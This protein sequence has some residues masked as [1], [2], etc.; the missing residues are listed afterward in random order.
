MDKT[1]PKPRKKIS[2]KQT[3]VHCAQCGAAHPP[4]AKFCAECGTPI[5]K[6]LKD[7]PQWRPLTVLFCD[8][9]GSTSLAE[10][11]DP[12]EF[13][14][15]LLA[16]Q[17]CCHRVIKQFGGAIA[18]FL[19]DGVLAY[20]GYPRAYEHDAQR[21]VEASLCLLESVAALAPPG[22]AL[23]VRIGLHTGMVIIGSERAAGYL[24]A[25]AMG[26]TPHMAARLQA[27]AQP[28]TVLLSPT[29]ARQV[30]DGFAL[31]KL[32]ARR[33]KGFSRE[34]LVYQ[35]QG[36]C[37]SSQAKAATAPF[38]LAPLI[39]RYKE[40]ERGRRQWQR[41]QRAGKRLGLQIVGEPGIGK[42]RFIRVLKE[43]A[44][45]AGGVVLECRCSPYY[46]HSALRPFIDLLQREFGLKRTDSQAAKSAKLKQGINSAGLSVS[47]LFPFLG[48][49][50]HIAD[51]S[52]LPSLAPHKARERTLEALSAL[53]TARALEGPTLLIIEDLQWAD[54]S[55]L[56]LTEK[57]VRAR[58][59]APLLWVL[60]HRSEFEI[61]WRLP[62]RT[63]PLTL[64]R[65]TEAQ[66]EALATGIAGKPL[67]Q[68]VSQHILAHTD[69]IP[70]FIEELTKAVLESG[71]LQERDDHYELRGPLPHALIP[72]TIFDSL[73]PRFDR[74]GEA[75]P[76]AQAAAA[77][78]REFSYPLLEA[79][80]AHSKMRLRHALDKLQAAQL[81]F[82]MGN[83]PEPVYCF[84]HALIRDAA[85]HSLL[86]SQRQFIHGRIARILEQ[87]F[88][89]A[90]ETQ[91][92]LLAYHYQEAALYRPA[93]DYWQKAGQHAVKHSANHE[94]IRHFKQGLALLPGLPDPNERLQK[95]FI[96][97]SALGAPLIMTQGY[98]APEV[99]NTYARALELSQK[100][101]EP[102]Q[103]FTAL[104]G[105]WVFYL[106]KAEYRKALKLG[107][108]LM[109]IATG[110][111]DSGLRLEAHMTLG[112]PFFYCA[113]FTQ[114]CA[115][116]G[117]ALALYIP[118]Q[119]RAHA[120]LYGQ[121]PGIACSGFQ[122]WALLL[123][124]YPDQA[125]KIMAHTLR[126]AKRQSHPF[127]LAYALHFKALVHQVCD[128]PPWVEKITHT[129]IALCQEQGFPLFSGSGM[130]FQGWALVEKGNGQ[131]GIV[132]MQRGIEI[133]R[134]TG[135][136]LARTYWSALLAESYGTIQQVE[137]G[138]AAITEAFSTMD[139]NEA[140]FYEAE[141]Y[142][143]K[144]DLLLRLK[145]SALEAED[146]F[147][148]ALAIAKRQKTKLLELRAATCLGRLWKE[149]GK[150]QEA[151]KLLGEIYNW[152]TEGFDTADLKQAEAL[153][154]ELKYA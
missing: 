39:G 130:I 21:A 98:S 66:S 125:R 122:A 64:G 83:S 73:M 17:A 12:E 149:S 63:L 151:R 20:F 94:A 69:G 42:S 46:Q 118:Q 101:G 1:L 93:I 97:Q 31:K 26:D 147:Q 143:I 75:L 33:L 65:L 15:L 16:Y 82:C 134:S 103:R 6:P 40:L 152:F 102:Q 126:L 49:L 123:M 113:N 37:Q 132:R 142:R 128:E 54:P 44:H 106:V 146:Y 104:R 53:L 3:P 32:N 13:R 121:D 11:K 154:I 30:R 18:Q 119:H 55:T 52:T 48:K 95:E 47:E 111:Q 38:D 79:V 139:K 115:H 10:R 86:K 23:K 7:E 114:A 68:D 22:E 109:G 67:P 9:V 144:G 89:E 59:R 135:A 71:I 124:G 51:G 60:S 90:A 100:G 24:T 117:E 41:V 116:L 107:E 153:L 92:E 84:K 85:Y 4:Q 14:T 43:E 108:Q 137:K 81:L 148:Q 2:A 145:G 74:L 28:N 150:R 141:L 136:E 45:Q 77:L 25:Q 110:E 120:F 70:L 96:L 58:E 105:L 131:E 112:I 8:L 140:F 5:L 50:L 133:W 72:Q 56:E 19:G 138:L 91:P 78:G 57:L 61:P 35:V 62:L 99:E 76:V 127:S 87:K 129:Q 88:P 27:A 34:T 36:T 80:S 29:T